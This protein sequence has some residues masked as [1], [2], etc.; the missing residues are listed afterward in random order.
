MIQNVLRILQTGLSTITNAKHTGRPLRRCFV[1]GSVDAL[2]KYY[3]AF[4]A[5]KEAGRHKLRIVT[6]FTYCAN[7][8]DKDADGM[9]GEPDF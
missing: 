3:E 8:E 7:E 9:I 6:I 4:K 5:R 2:I 1:L